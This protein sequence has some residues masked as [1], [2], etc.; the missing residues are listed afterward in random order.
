[1]AK[2]EDAEVLRRLEPG[3]TPTETFRE[4]SGG[5]VPPAGLEKA[6]KEVSAAIPSGLDPRNELEA[7]VESQD[8]GRAFEKTLLGTLMSGSSFSSTYCGASGFDWNW[9]YTNRTGDANIDKS[10]ADTSYEYVHSYSGTF[11]MRQRYQLGAWITAGETWLSTGDTIYGYLHTWPDT[12][13]RVAI[14]NASG[15]TWHLN[16]RGYL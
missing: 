7:E 10:G 14:D 6:W 9:C 12:K 16:F 2:G 1:M 15:N 11:R 3:L 8:S 13:H 5:A 4:L